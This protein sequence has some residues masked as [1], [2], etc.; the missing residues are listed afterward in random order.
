[1]QEEASPILFSPQLHGH[2]PAQLLHFLQVVIQPFGL[3]YLPS[4]EYIF[5]EK[6]KIV[7]VITT[8]GVIR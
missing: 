2:P 4:N 3:S 7:H 6:K 8:Y 5:V 1:M